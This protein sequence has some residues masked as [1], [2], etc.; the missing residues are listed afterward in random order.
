MVQQQQQHKTVGN[1]V[2]EL[3]RCFKYVL[4]TWSRR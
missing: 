1:V 4:C 3:E 2:W